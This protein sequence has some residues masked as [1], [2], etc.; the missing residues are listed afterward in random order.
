MNSS[1][2]IQANIHNLTSL[3]ETA[4]TPFQSYVKGTDYDYCV[5][6]NSDWP[7]RLWFNGEID[8]EKAIKSALDKMASSSTD[9]MLPLWDIY[10]N[11]YHQ[12]LEEHGCRELFELLGMTLQLGNPFE[13]Q[14]RLDISLVSSEEDARLWSDIYPQAFGYRIS[15]AILLETLGDINFYLACYQG[16]PVGTAIQFNTANVSGIHGVGVIPEMRRRGFAGEIMKFVLNRAIDA[17][18]DYATLQASEM[19]K[20][21]YLKMGFEEQFS[22]KHYGLESRN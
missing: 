19:G 13:E 21:L 22:I 10:D 1:E 2:L 7:N 8:G 14:G 20:G 6:P 16:Q 18:A 4:G 3:W 15:R 12:Y 11:G 5:I 9:L 17:K